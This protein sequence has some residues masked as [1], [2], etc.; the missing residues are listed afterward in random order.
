MNAN[1]KYNM[2]FGGF[3]GT[4]LFVTAL[5]LG[6]QQVAQGNSRLSSGIEEISSIENRP[7]PA[8]SP[9]SSMGDLRWYE[10]QQELLVSTPAVFTGFG[11]LRKFEN[12]LE[13]LSQSR[14]VPAG[15][16]DLRR[17]EAGQ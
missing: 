4:L 9:Y 15:M 5:I 16:G 1:R 14:T 3:L 11:D 13:A 12:Q 6:S 17:F 10:R 7:S 8:G 2:V